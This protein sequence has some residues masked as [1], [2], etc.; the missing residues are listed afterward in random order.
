MSQLD[1]HLTTEELSALLDDE[2]EQKEPG[3]EQ[4]GHLTTCQHC[5]RE[6]AE[7]RQTVNL[8]HALPQPTLPRSFLLPAGIIPITTTD[9]QTQDTPNIHILG[10]TNSTRQ[11]RPIRTSM[12]HRVLSLAGTLA[13][14]VGILFILSGLIPLTLPPTP[15][16]AGT[17]TASTNSSGKIAKQANSSAASSAN[18]PVVPNATGQ[19]SGTPIQ[20]QQDSQAVPAPDTQTQNAPGIQPAP[21]QEVVQSPHPPPAPPFL[22]LDATGVRIGLGIL[23]FIAGMMGITVGRERSK[24]VRS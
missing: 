3:D 4:G 13:A 19:D 8:L 6:L 18:Q 5:Q 11:R 23:L 21:K 9:T 12:G 20:N 15:T 10:L 1:R 2:F 22:D 7:L 16:S 17:S 14:V 24:G